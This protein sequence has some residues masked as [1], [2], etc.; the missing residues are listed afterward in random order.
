MMG[1]KAMRAISH[2]AV[3]VSDMKRSLPFYRD[4]LG[5]KVSLDTEE[6]IK[7]SAKSGEPA[8]VKRHAIYMRWEDGPHATFIVLSQNHPVPSGEP[9]RLNQVGI[10]H[11]SF[12]VDNLKERVEKLKAA[13]VKFVVEPNES[14]G[15]AYG[16]PHEKRILTTIF[17]DPDGTLIQFDQRLN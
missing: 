13:G 2:V 17:K 14:A 7:F 11:F 1:G 16:E 6:T 9:L 4:L 12:W 3:G 5:L 15:E 8:E 10:H